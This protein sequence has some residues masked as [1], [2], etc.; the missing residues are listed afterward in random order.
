MAAY[1]VAVA[2]LAGERHRTRT[3]E[4]TLAR[5]S[6]ADVGFALTSRLG[7]VA[8]AALIPEPR[9]RNGNYVFGT[10]GKDFSTSD[11]HDLMV[12][13]LTTRQ[14]SSLLEATEL[15]E[16]F[17]ALEER[18]DVDLSDETDRWKSRHEITSVLTRWTTSHDLADI[19]VRFDTAG[20][21]WAP[22]QT[23]KQLVE[24]DPDCSSANPMF[25]DIVQAGVGAYPIA[26]SPIDFA[27]FVRRPA[28]APPQLGEHTTEVLSSILGLSGAELAE[29][30]ENSIIGGA[31]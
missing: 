4:G 5:I 1:L 13:A 3:G 6:L 23:F 15:T 11:G 27:N 28:I 25:T 22:Y 9:E 12:V 16:E 20:V 24:E 19:R 31:D 14:W 18:L 10:F 2:L 7:M 30:R 29:L 17:R 26:G 8:E 21:L